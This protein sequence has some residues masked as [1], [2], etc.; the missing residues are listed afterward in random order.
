MSERDAQLESL[1]KHH[2]IGVWRYL[3]A[4]GASALDAEEVTQD[5]FLVEWRR[6]V[7]ASSEE[8]VAGFLRKTARFLWLRRKRDADRRE[9]RALEAADRLW[10]RSCA[11]DSGEACLAALRECIAHLP[12]RDREVVRATYVEP[13]GSDREVLAARFGLK[14]NGLKMLLQRVRAR[15]RTCLENRLGGSR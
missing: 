14:P 2:Q 9:R 11:S 10:E 15:L 13:D 7:A 12:P 8:S 6:G 1:V 5:A 4:L 3:R